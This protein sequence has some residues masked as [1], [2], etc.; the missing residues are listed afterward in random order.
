[1]HAKALKVYSYKQCTVTFG[2][3][4]VLSIFTAE[5]DVIQRSMCPSYLLSLTHLL[6]TQ[7]MYTVFT[8]P[9]IE[10]TITMWMCVC[11]QSNVD[12]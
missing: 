5:L 4:S 12:V 1:M 3:G 2:A 7:F 9:H 6:C 10:Y 8:L 11:T